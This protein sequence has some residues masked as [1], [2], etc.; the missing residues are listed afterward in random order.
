MEES[1]SAREHWDTVYANKS[2]DA[3]SWYQPQFQQSLTWID[4]CQLSRGAH[5]V[6]IGGGA[7]TLVDDLLARGFEKLSVVDLSAHA[8]A[9]S[10]Q[11]LGES[12][13]CVHWVV[14]DVTTPLFEDASVD[15]WHDRAVFHFLTEDAVRSAYVEHV[16]RCVRPGGF[17]ILATFGPG[18]PERCSGLP[19][20][21]YGPAELAQALGA[22]FVLLEQASENHVTP[23]GSSQAFTY[24][25]C[26]RA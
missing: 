13:E 6:D 1:M 10:R 2:P 25:L 4:R 12:G 22:G 3:V 24:V 5:L 7:S 20:V 17:V 23:W 14:G 21:R 9:H 19:V 11:R 15:L 26:Q 18:G 8:L 16:S